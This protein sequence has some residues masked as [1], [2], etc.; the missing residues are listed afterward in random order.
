MC[1][2]QSQS[3]TVLRLLFHGFLACLVCGVA[4]ADSL[5]ESDRQ[6]LLEKLAKLRSIAEGRVNSRNGVA[7]AA[8]IDRTVFGAHLWSQSKTW[9]PE[10]LLSTVPAVATT[11]LGGVAGLWLGSR[12]SGARKA[13]WMTAAGLLAV[14]IGLAWSLVFPLNKALWT[15]SYVWFTAGAAA[16]FLSLCYALIDVKGWKTWSRRNSS[17]CWKACR[18]SPA[19]RSIPGA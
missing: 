2:R 12:A 18:P 4:A 1:H 16:V 5:S 8:Y 17:R 19:I 3:R 15:S 11:L 14:A 9:D 10:G 13:L 6:L 7:L